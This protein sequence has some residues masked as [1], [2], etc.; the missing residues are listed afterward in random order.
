[1]MEHIY[2]PKIKTTP[3]NN[4]CN[5]PQKWVATEKIHG[6]QFVVGVNERE[7]KFG[8][9]KAWLN[10]NEPFFGWQVLRSVLEASAVKIYSD[11]N[12]TGSLYI[13]GELFGG[14]YPHSD[15]RNNDLFTPVQTGIWYSPSLQYAVF[16]ILFIKD[17]IMYFMSFSEVV[18]LVEKTS[19]QTVPVLAYGSY[20]SLKKLPV[21]Y[22]SSV[23]E[24]YGLP[25][26]ENNVAEG[27]VLKPDCEIAASDRPVIK[28]KIPEFSENRFDE[29]QPFNSQAMPGV[30]ELSEILSM[31]INSAR[32]ES[33]RSKT[34]DEPEAIIEESMLDVMVDLELIFP[35]KMASLSEG[36]EKAITKIIEEKVRDCLEGL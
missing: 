12:G 26:I 19:L 14:S 13:Y 2:Y 11:Y 5:Y 21:R 7:V 3:D 35:L 22:T 30:D 6:A 4:T 17:E 8:K 33:A 18:K 36:E 15:V 24:K 32:I 16:D 34:G 29:C 9:R 20:E 28:Y 25:P 10:D 31:M 27:F 1:M 23:Y